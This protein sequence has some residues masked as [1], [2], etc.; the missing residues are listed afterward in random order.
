[1]A[2]IS[3][4]VIR[5]SIDGTDVVNFSSFNY[6][7][8]TDNESILE[9]GQNALREHTALGRIP[10]YFVGRQ[11]YLSDAENSAKA[12][13]LCSD[14]RDVMYIAV[15][16]MLGLIA[17]QALNDEFDAAFIDRHAHYNLYDGIRS[18]DKPYYVY[19]HLDTCGL[20]K[21][22]QDKLKPGQ[23]PL[24][25]TDGVFAA[26]QD[27]APLDVLKELADAYDGWLL[28]DESHSFGV[29]GKGRG[30]AHE[31]GVQEG[32]VIYG[33]SCSKG[34][35]AYGGLIIGPAWIIPKMRSCNAANGTNPGLSAAASMTAAS[36]SYLLKHPEINER[37]QANIARLYTDLAEAGYACE[38][39]ISAGMAFFDGDFA[40]KKD[41]QAEL[42]QKGYLVCCLVY[43]G[44]GSD[45]FLKITVTA[46]H[47]F[48]EID[49]VVREFRKLV[50]PKQG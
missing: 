27:V 43:Q 12:Y 19:D 39:R 29:L 30:A 42:A 41:V 21:L 37:L 8:L 20:K 3:R 7:A 47:S 24:I 18:V 38:G 44:S 31:F 22:L 11:K 5:F 25:I 4:D 9:A 14:S 13:F 32:R 16:Y 48:D 17:V 1:M 15:G 23:V 50:P 33:G 28:V 35:A 49:G 45:G 26:S 10:A 40:F 6:L 46:G 34:F 36:L 2:N